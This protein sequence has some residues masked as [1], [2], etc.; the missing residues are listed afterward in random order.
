MHIVA[1]Y[2]P[3]EAEE[4]ST[5][6]PVQDWESEEGQTADGSYARIQADSVV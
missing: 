5:A 4:M 1:H 3:E 2:Y 6:A